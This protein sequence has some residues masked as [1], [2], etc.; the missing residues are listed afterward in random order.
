M[1]K[2]L[3][4]GYYGF[5]NFGDEA[6]LGVL[7]SKLKGA[8]VTVLSSDP[9]KTSKLYG[10]KSINSFDAK[11][12]L[13]HLN[14]FDALI[15]GGGSLI[16]NVTSIKSLIY[17]CGLISMMGAMN[18]P[19]N[20]K[21]VIIFAQGIGPIKGF[22]ANLIAKNAFKKCTYISV[23]DE[24]SQKLLKKYGVESNLVCDPIFDLPLPPRSRTRKIGIQLRR[25]E[26]LTDELFDGIV[27]Q[28]AFKFSDRE[29]ELISFQDSE[30]VGIS[31]VFLHKLKEK[32]PTINAKIVQ[33]LNNQQII[34]RVGEY[35]YLIAMR[36]HACLLGL[37]YGIKTLAISYDPK[38]ENL[39]KDAK[40]PY[41][42]MDSSKNDYKKAFED[43][44]K[45]TSFN[46]LNFANSKQFDWSQTGIDFLLG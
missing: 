33:G 12:V 9:E 37:K 19:K 28:V 46:L 42:V 25:F 4:S 35:D 44:D 14:E 2:I 30:D 15:S 29:I 43:L 17:Y 6:I 21:D 5:D 22:W 32:H 7:L 13:E 38:V 36:F 20:P 24:N 26:T 23:R 16:Q 31:E 41:F 3:V 18:S 34:N 8:D 11:T 45:L 40:I 27:K 1:K 10:V 39:A